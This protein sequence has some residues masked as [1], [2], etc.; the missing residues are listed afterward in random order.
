MCIN[1]DEGAKEGDLGECQSEGVEDW[2]VHLDS[3]S[4]SIITLDS[5][6]YQ[7]VATYQA[8]GLNFLPRLA[9]RGR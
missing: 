1:K 8:R 2:L 3:N 7:R 4:C 9:V 6:H 5:I